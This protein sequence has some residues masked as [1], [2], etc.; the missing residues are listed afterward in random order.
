MNKLNV[1][2]LAERTGVDSSGFLKRSSIVGHLDMQP[3]IEEMEQAARSWHIAIDHAAVQ[4][5][6]AHESSAAPGQI[7]RLAV[8]PWLPREDLEQEFIGAAR[9][10]ANFGWT[11]PPAMSPREFFDL[12]TSSDWA[13]VDARFITFYRRCDIAPSFGVGSP[14]L[15]R[16]HPLLEQCLENY[17]TGNYLICV[18]ALITVLE[19]A[20]AFPE[21]VAFIRGKERK[22]F[23]ERKIAD[24]GSDLLGRALWESVDIFVSHLFE[25]APFGDI[26]P[27]RLNRHWILHGRDAPDWGQ[28]DALRLFHALSTLSLIFL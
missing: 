17:R 26:R 1:G 27:P 5:A 23:F 21:G 11:I 9:K 8:D 24:C 18:P 25:R 22:A 7:A 4:R 2:E 14:R 10:L 28:A 19:G 16:W 3:F 6:L 15:A 12:S 20:I 13:T